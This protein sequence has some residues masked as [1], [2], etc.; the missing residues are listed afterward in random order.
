M[1]NLIGIFR[2]MAKYSNHQLKQILAIT[3]ALAD[4]NRIRIIMALR[5]QSLCVCQ[6]TEL[7]KL[8]PSTVSKHIAILKQAGL[9][10][11]RKEGRWIHYYIPS[12]SVSAQA[13]EAVRLL[14]DNLGK[15]SRITADRKRLLEILK[16][17]REVLC[18]RM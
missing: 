8:A 10:D 16:V 13:G 4:E 3:K 15:D 6:I 2:H 1:G 7:L 18:R 17:D 9:V 11:S 12:A 14:A 5:R